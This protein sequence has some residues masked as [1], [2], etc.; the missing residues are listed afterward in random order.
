ML[1]RSARTRLMTSPMT[2]L[3]HC[4]KRGQC[5]SRSGFALVYPALRNKVIAQLPA[6]LLC[7]Q[8]RAF[9]I[10]TALVGIFLTVDRRNVRWISV[11]IGS[12][13]TKLLAVRVDPLPQGFA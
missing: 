12:P 3:M 1:P 10:Q 8:S 9:D 5:L 4:K 13:N 7:S 6:A 11:E 2:R